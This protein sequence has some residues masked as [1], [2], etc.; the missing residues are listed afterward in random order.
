[1]CV[2]RP[3]V[4]LGCIVSAVVL[5][6]GVHVQAE[7]RQTQSIV[8]AEVKGLAPV[9]DE[10]LQ[11]NLPRAEEADLYNGLHLMVLEDRRVPV[12][13][14]QM[15]LIGAGG[16]YDPPDHA[17]LASFTASLLREGTE[18]LSSV[19][20]AEALETLASRLTISTDMS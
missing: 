3:Y 10:I 15:I 12:V 14:F 19:E 20:I 1:M 8:G 11:V 5:L 6:I 13:S 18:T 2:R 9:S 4:V 17:G 7:K 16:Y